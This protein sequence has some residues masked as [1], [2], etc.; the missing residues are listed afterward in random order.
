MKECKKCNG[1]FDNDLFYKG[2]AT[3]KECYKEKVRN[4]REEKRDHYIEYEK[5]RSNLPHRVKA[6]EDYAKTKKGIIAGNKAKINWTNTNLVKRSANL[7][8]CNAVRDGK[9]TKSKTCESCGVEHIRIHGHHDDYNYP[10]IVRWLCPSC[11]TAW[12]RENGSGMNG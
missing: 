11:H 7:I 1:V 10:M 4:H 9:L 8:V 6:R 3:C 12:H 5:K 2:H